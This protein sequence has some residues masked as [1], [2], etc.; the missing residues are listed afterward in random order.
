MTQADLVLDWIADAIAGID[1]GP[2]YYIDLYPNN[3]HLWSMS[4]RMTQHPDAL[5]QEIWDSMQACATP[6]RIQ[7]LHDLDQAGMPQ[8]WVSHKSCVL[9]LHPLL[10]APVRV[11]ML[12]QHKD[13][14]DVLIKTFRQTAIRKILR[15]EAARLTEGATSRV[16]FQDET[17]SAHER[18]D[19]LARVPRSEALLKTFIGFPL[20]LHR[21][22]DVAVLTG[23]GQVFLTMTVPA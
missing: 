21:V 17:V 10:G 18:M 11:L 1:V 19:L 4:S 3:I 15:A 13:M 14:C 20:T 16:L 23:L 22:G 8:V 9:V 2:Q 12:R 7:A 6:Q 5:N